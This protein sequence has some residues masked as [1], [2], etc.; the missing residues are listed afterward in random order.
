MS[1]LYLETQGYID[2][3]LKLMSTHNIRKTLTDECQK[4]DELLEQGREMV[5]QKAETVEMMTKQAWKLRR[6]LGF[7][8]WFREYIVL[9]LTLLRYFNNHFM[10]FYGSNYA[11]RNLFQN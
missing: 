7:R 1:C 11:V 2:H 3:A 8:F 6:Q 5:E 10:Y 4:V 9:Q